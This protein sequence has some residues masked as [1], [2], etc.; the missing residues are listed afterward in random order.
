MPNNDEPEWLV[1]D[2]G[3]IWTYEELQEFWRESEET[4]DRNWSMMGLGNEWNVQEPWEEPMEP[5]EEPMEPWEEPME[6]SG[7]EDVFKWRS[8]GA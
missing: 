6:P 1:E 2:S 7:Q 4:A 3:R 8:I 5:W